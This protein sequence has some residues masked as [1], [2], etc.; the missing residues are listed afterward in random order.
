MRILTLR[1]LLAVHVIT[2]AE[3]GVWQSDLRMR[4]GVTDE[5]F[6]EEFNRSDL[7]QFTVTK[8][9]EFTLQLVCFNLFV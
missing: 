8:L 6:V 9:K 2:A 7:Q 1:W 5:M 3:I 4:K